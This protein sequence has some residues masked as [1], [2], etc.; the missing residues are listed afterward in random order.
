[1]KFG[2]LAIGALFLFVASACS[3]VFDG[4][5]E[6]RD[7]SYSVGGSPTVVVNND[8]GRITVNPGADGTVR[9][10]ATLRKP[11]ELEYEIV[12]DG[13][14][15]S[16][17]AKDTTSG[18][19]RIGTSPGADIEITAPSDTSV[20][21]RTSN[22]R[23]EVISMHRSGT[24][25]SSNGKIVLEDV[26]GDF[27]VTTSN[28]GVT[29][30]RATGTCDIETSNGRIEFDGEIVPGGDNRMRTSN[31]SVEV[32]LRGRPASSLTRP[33]PMARFPP[34]CRF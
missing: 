18:N 13:D 34:S 4:P 9:V 28:G 26:V 24:V 2:Y 5:T 22:G 10:M 32:T 21:L 3:E 16:I 30:S 25:H 17:V 15:I 27:D 6:T 1:M 31:G 8:N 33:R 7:N 19:F 23:V 12:Q 29:V 20:Q 14:S 11:D